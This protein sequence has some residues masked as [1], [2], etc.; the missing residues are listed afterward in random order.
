MHVDKISAEAA[1][2]FCEPATEFID[3][4]EE[5]KQ[6]SEI[7]CSIKACCAYNAGVASQ[8]GLIHGFLFILQPYNKCMKCSQDIRLQENVCLFDRNPILTKQSCEKC[9]VI[10]SQVLFRVRNVNNRQ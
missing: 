8:N 9:K 10:N 7:S 6:L 1:I 5:A 3:L 4:C 2:A